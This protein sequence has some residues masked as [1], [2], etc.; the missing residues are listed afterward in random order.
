M[1][2]Q[3]SHSLVGFV[4]LCVVS[5]VFGVVQTRDKTQDSSLPRTHKVG[6]D[7]LKVL[8]TKPHH[9]LT[10]SL[11]MGQ[12]VYDL[13]LGNTVSVFLPKKTD[14]LR[15]PTKKQKKREVKVKINPQA[16]ERLSGSEPVVDEYDP[17]LDD[18]QIKRL[19]RN[20]RKRKYPGGVY[21][22]RYPK[23]K[24]EKRWIFVSDRERKSIYL[25]PLSK[26]P[27]VRR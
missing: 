3:V 5:A 20:A 11:S 15:K 25:V 2:E 21:V 24:P 14:L 19:K 12:S 1:G 23:A 17:R 9:R 8:K 16:I 4:S 7:F 18:R 13:G 27:A 22:L 10:L 26:V 6:D